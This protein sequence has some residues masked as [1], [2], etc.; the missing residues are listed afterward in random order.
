M[1][2]LFSI[3]LV[4][5]VIL[6]SLPTTVFAVDTDHA[7]SSD[8]PIDTAKWQGTTVVWQKIPDVNS[9]SLDISSRVTDGL[10]SAVIESEIHIKLEGTKVMVTVLSGKYINVTYDKDPL[11]ISTR[12]MFTIFP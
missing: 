4:L 12:T 3:L 9:Y 8:E 6:C 11:W 5:S 2:R 10:H 1:K 7:A